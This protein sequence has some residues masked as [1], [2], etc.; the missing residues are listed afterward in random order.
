MSVP[1]HALA[2][3][4]SQIVEY[5]LDVPSSKYARG[6]GPACG[7]A[8]EHGEQACGLGL[9]VAQPFEPILLAGVE[10]AAAAIQ[11]VEEAFQIYVHRVSTS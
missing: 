2:A 9:E 10:F 3:S 7:A 11:L 1:P 4:A 6:G 5:P 8:H